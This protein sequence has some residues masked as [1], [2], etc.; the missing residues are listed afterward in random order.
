MPEVSTRALC[1]GKAAQTLRRLLPT[2]LGATAEGLGGAGPPHERSLIK[3][4]FVSKCQI[5]HC[6]CACRRMDIAHLRPE[7]GIFDAHARHALQHIP[8]QKINW[9]VNAK[10]DLDTAEPNICGTVLQICCL[11][12]KESSL[13]CPKCTAPDFWDR[14]CRPC[15]RG[16]G[17]IGL[18]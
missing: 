12:V 2:Q 8:N 1:L 16:F 5:R 17:R 10:Q 11:C 15:R 6:D 14:F 18:A 4:G 7:Q 3:S 9:P 13:S